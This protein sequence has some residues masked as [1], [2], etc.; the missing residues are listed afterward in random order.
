MITTSYLFGEKDV[1]TGFGTQRETNQRKA[2]EKML[3]QH[4]LLDDL[5][6]DDEDV[7]SNVS[8]ADDVRFLCSNPPN[9]LPNV[10]FSWKRD[11]RDIGQIEI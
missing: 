9:H 4:E 6:D 8:A 10:R 5:I 2:A 11:E 7:R 1:E 3:S